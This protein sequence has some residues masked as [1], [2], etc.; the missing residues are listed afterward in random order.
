VHGLLGRWLLGADNPRRF[1]KRIEGQEFVST[2]LGDLAA[3]QHEV[4]GLHGAAESAVEQLTRSRK[5]V[6]IGLE[7]TPVLVRVMPDQLKKLDS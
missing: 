1:E 6:T 3:H 5:P 4:Q 2:Q 7:A